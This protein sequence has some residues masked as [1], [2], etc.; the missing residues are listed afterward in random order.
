MILVL[1]SNLLILITKEGQVVKVDK[2]RLI[3]LGNVL[4]KVITKIIATCL[5]GLCSRIIFQNQFSFILGCNIGDYLARGSE[6]FN[7]I[8]LH[9]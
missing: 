2:Y 6:C 9:N 5:S 1:N 7:V 3:A 8:C 4:F